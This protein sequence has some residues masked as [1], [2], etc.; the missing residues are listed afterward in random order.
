MNGATYV[1]KGKDDDKRKVYGNAQFLC[2]DGKIKFTFLP[3]DNPKYPSP[4][5]RDGKLS[6]I[7]LPKDLPIDIWLED[8]A[9]DVVKIGLNSDGDKIESIQPFEMQCSAKFVGLHR[10]NGEGTPPMW[11][12]KEGTYNDNGKEKP[13]IALNFIAYFEI[14]GNDNI[15][16]GVK[17][18]YFLRYLYQEAHNKVGNP[19]GLAEYSFV[20]KPGGY[21]KST[22]GI[23]LND[24][25]NKLEITGDVT[26]PEDGNILPEIERLGLLYDKPLKINIEKGWLN[27]ISHP[28]V[29]G[30]KRQQP[31]I[32][33]SGEDEIGFLKKEEPASNPDE[34]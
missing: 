10:P 25:Q 31:E 28:S 12:E 14:T 18:P 8:G 7:F 16:K 15:F 9:E 24:F 1:K 13:Y 2:V 6:E 17:I 29:F 20:V 26:W 3:S 27:S 33:E 4:T 32:Q 23:K 11:T 21:I 22:H 5:F 19:T 30:M 34:M